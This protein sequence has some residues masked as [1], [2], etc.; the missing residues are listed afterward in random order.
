VN[1]RQL[2]QIALGVL[3]VWALLNVINAVITFFEQ[4]ETV[5]GA[6]GTTAL[7]V[8]VPLLLMLALS[9][10]LVFHNARLA[11]AI[12]PDAA[13]AA[14]GGTHD[15]ARVLVAVMGTMMVLQA[16]PTAVNLVLNIF[17]A[18]GD[19]DAMPGGALRRHLIGM[20]LDL[21]CALYLVFRPERFV[22]FLNRPRSGPAEAAA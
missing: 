11:A 17:A 7:V 3:G 2:A 20:G 13:A 19:P 6:S 22:A 21:A 1:A 14:V 15:V 9:Y 16:L 4:M 10:V 5:G 8:G 18:V 12:M